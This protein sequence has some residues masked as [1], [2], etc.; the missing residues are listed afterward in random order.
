MAQASSKPRFFALRVSLPSLYHTTMPPQR[1]PLA[2]LMANRPRGPEYSPYT[3]ARS[4]ACILL[5]LRNAK[6]WISLTRLVRAFEGPLLLR[7]SIPIELLFLVPV[8]QLFTILETRESC[9]VLSDSSLNSRSISGERRP[10]L[11]YLIPI[12]RTSY[13]RIGSFTSV[14]RYDLLLYLK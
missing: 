14:R 9:F 7:F 6:L 13:T 4:L 12:S 5:A 11:I 8:V 10:V 3:R 1:T 2:E